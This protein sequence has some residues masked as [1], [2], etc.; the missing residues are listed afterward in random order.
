M[1]QKCWL[2][3]ILPGVHLASRRMVLS[4]HKM[5]RT[6]GMDR[7]VYPRIHCAMEG[8]EAACYSSAYLPSCR[9]D[10]YEFIELQ[11]DERNEQRNTEYKPVGTVWSSRSL[12][13]SL[14]SQLSFTVIFLV[15]R[16]CTGLSM[17]PLIFKVGFLA[18]SQITI[19]RSII[20]SKFQRSLKCV[21]GPRSSS[22]K[23][24]TD[25]ESQ[26][27][28]KGFSIGVEWSVIL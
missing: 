26:R 24:S 19:P 4:A 28:T 13:V 17:V 11:P 20:T 2:V 27:L 6:S 10:I 14:W 22:N 15:P 25:T 9:G 3:V 7:H 1:F 5:L 18:K 21:K 8:T 16:S 12:I 23:M